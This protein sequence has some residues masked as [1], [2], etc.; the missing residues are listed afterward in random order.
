MKEVLIFSKDKFEPIKFSNITAVT[1]DPLTGFFEMKRE[2]RKILVNTANVNI[3]DIREC[4]D[5][6]R[7]A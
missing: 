7:N 1:V 5:E 2:D 3:I 6:G 4:K